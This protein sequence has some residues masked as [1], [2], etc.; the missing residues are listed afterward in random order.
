ME[1][2]NCAWYQL[3]YLLPTNQRKVITKGARV[4]NKDSSHKSQHNSWIQQS[5]FVI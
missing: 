2:N 1:T 3:K 4:N 5:L